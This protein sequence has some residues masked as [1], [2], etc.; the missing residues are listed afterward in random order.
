MFSYLIHPVTGTKVSVFSNDGKTLLKSYVRLLQSGGSNTPNANNPCNACNHH[1]KKMTQ[2]GPTRASEYKINQ[3]GVSDTYN[4]C[5]NCVE[6]L[7]NEQKQGR[8]I[9]PKLISGYLQ[10]AEQ[11]KKIDPR[12][13]Q[14]REAARTYSQSYRQ[15][16][17]AKTR[18]PHGQYTMIFNIVEDFINKLRQNQV[19]YIGNKTDRNNVPLNNIYKMLFIIPKGRPVDNPIKVT[20]VYLESH[21]LLVDLLNTYIRLIAQISR[22]NISS[23]DHNMVSG[24]LVERKKQILKV[25]KWFIEHDDSGG[26]S[27]GYPDLDMPAAPKDS[28]YV[29]PGVPTTALPTT[30]AVSQ[31]RQPIALTV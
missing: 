17:Q 18:Q 15:T 11:A 27:E 3:S 13:G 5:I 9:D 10:K 26:G 7:L 8:A 14:I 2:Y 29:F 1:Y 24:Q 28:L 30:P 31:S 12:L 6:K 23:S 20:K 19:V 16:P 22:T 25:L 4:F 21:T